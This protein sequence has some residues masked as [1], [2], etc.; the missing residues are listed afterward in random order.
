[1]NGVFALVSNLNTFVGQFHPAYGSSTSI[2]LAASPNRTAVRQP[3]AALEGHKEH[4][5]II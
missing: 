5:K 1:M 3:K 2:T 4:E